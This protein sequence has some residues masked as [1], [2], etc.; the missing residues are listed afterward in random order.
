MQGLTGS[1]IDA[2]VSYPSLAAAGTVNLNNNNWH[3]V[4][5]TSSPPLLTG[6]IKMCASP[7]DGQ[8]VN[9]RVDGAITT[10][11]V[12]PNIGQSVT[13]A[14]TTLAIGGIIEGIYRASNTTW[15]F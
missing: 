9:I 6:T 3:V 12:S 8:I 1:I 14:P 5:I 4:V 13:G 10:L 11:T 15:Y 2:A 7:Y